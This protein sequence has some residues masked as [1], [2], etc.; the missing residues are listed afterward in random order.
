LI[1]G[2]ELRPAALFDFL[3]QD[4]HGFL[5]DFDAFATGNRGACGIDSGENLGAAAL[6]FDPKR[7]SRLYGVFS[8]GEAAALDRLSDE[9]LLLGGEVYLHIAN[10]MG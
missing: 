2:G 8:A 5:S 1:L 3:G 10:V 4:T 9:I 6:S 7:Q